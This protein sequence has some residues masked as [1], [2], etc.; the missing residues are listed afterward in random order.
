[1][2]WNVVNGNIDSYSP[3]ATPVAADQIYLADSGASNAIRRAT[4]ANVVPLSP[5]ETAP[6]SPN[7]FN[8]EFNEGSAD[9]AT[10]GWTVKTW[11]G[12][13]M[14]RAGDVIPSGNN[15]SIAANTY[16]STIV[17]G[18]LRFQAGQD[19]FIHKAWTGSVSL[20]GGFARTRSATGDYVYMTLISAVPFVAASTR[21]A[22]VGEENAAFQGY[23]FTPPST[24]TNVYTASYSTVPGTADAQ[25]LDWNSGTNG[26]TFCTTTKATARMFAFGTATFASFVPVFAGL[27]I[28]LAATT[29]TYNWVELDY[30]RA[31]AQGTFFPV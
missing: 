7:A 2:L 9:L 23:Y 15:Q 11:A 13:T 28:Q 20:A 10:R 27:R 29:T 8:D 14:T 24:T 19:C 30:L 3:K 21:A 5:Y 22:F 18:R 26:L 16:L 6:A 12:T 17:N 4:L 31:Y 25:V 1:V